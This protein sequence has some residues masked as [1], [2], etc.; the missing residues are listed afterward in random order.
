MAET[1]TDEMMGA[2]HGEYSYDDPRSVWT[3]GART[4]YGMEPRYPTR[5]GRYAPSLSTLAADSAEEPLVFR[6]RDLNKEFEAFYLLVAAPPGGWWR[7]EE[8]RWRVNPAAVG[9][10]EA[11]GVPNA[12]EWR[13]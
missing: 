11:E 12:S 6:A 4:V 10:M 13:N 3:W 7:K 1:Y 2:L 8:G 9:Y 5:N